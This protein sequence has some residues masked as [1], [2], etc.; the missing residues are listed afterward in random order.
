MSVKA[1]TS[2]QPTNASQSQFNHGAVL[3]ATAGHNIGP[4]SIISAAKLNSQ[5]MRYLPTV[6]VFPLGL[7]F[8]SF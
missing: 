4:P 8:S 2:D 5:L 3:A 7:Q 6:E 1:D